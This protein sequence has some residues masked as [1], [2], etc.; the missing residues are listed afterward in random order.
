MPKLTVEIWSD[1]VCPW[2]WIGLTRLEKAL[3]GFAHREEVSVVHHAYRL[4][5]GQ[6]P[7][8]VEGMVARKMGGSAADAARMFAQVEA[9]AAE[10]GLTYHL[11]GGVTGDTLDAH[12]LVKLGEAGGRGLD[13]LK[14][15][16]RAYL[17]ERRSV[18]DHDSLLDLAVEAGLDRDRAHAVLSGT[19]FQTEIDVDQQA[20]NALGGNGVPFFVIGGKYGISGAQPTQAFA[21]VLEKAW[22]EQPARPEIFADGA[23]CGPDGC[24]AP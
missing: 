9:V 15:F 22:A 24:E 20:L 2:C 14:R 5:P 4:M 18:F 13:V 1:V 12:R 17:T 19:E 11:A 8:P 7:L 6:P 23:V 10:E 21:Q 16:Y 3:S